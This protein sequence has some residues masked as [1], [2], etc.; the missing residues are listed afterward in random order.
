MRNKNSIN[1]NEN[2]FISKEI[3]WAAIVLLLES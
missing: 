3:D 2:V 1:K